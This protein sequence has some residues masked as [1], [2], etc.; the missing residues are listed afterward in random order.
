[1][2]PTDWITCKYWFFLGSKKCSELGS[3]GG[4]F[5]S[6]KSMAMLRSISQPPKTYSRKE[7]LLSTFIFL[8]CRFPLFLIGVAKLPWQLFIWPRDM[9]QF[10][11]FECLPLLLLLKNSILIS[12]SMLSLQRSDVPIYTWFHLTKWSGPAVLTSDLYT[13]TYW[14]GARFFRMMKKYLL[15]C[16]ESCASGLNEQISVFELFVSSSAMILIWPFALEILLF[17]RGFASVWF[18]QVTTSWS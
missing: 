1:M 13:G 8:I 7:C 17:R 10:P 9:E 3:F 6:V 4:R 2:P 5:D 15:E 16:S 14:L 12:C 11:R 18:R